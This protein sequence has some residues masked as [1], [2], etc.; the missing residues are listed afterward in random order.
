VCRAGANHGPMAAPPEGSDP[1]WPPT[2][3]QGAITE[4]TTR[5]FSPPSESRRVTRQY[6]RRKDG[7]TATEI[8]RGP[9]FE[10]SGSGYGRSTRPDEILRMIADLKAT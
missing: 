7:T 1:E 2:N 9:L 5:D 8:T 10:F 6:K 3:T 4:I